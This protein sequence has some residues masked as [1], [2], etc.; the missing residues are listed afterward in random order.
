MTSTN[1]PGT[2]PLGSLFEAVAKKYNAKSANGQLTGS[3]F[4]YDHIQ[5]LAGYKQRTT[6]GL[7]KS[8]VTREL[9][10]Y[11][12]EFAER[13]DKQLGYSQRDITGYLFIQAE[14]GM[15]PWGRIF[16][17]VRACQVQDRDKPISHYFG[18]E[19][20]IQTKGQA[21]KKILIKLV[22][23]VNQEG[24]CFECRKEFPF[25]DITLDHDIPLSAKGPTELTNMQLMCK[26]C[27]NEKGSKY[28]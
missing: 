1:N 2:T 19:A 25:D 5:S 10:R 4:P 8:D 27:N 22:Q 11:L 17:T 28:G 3:K 13:N 12:K 7:S 20:F 23:Y 16:A 9:A 26:P 21:K 15:L 6:P 18:Y 24:Q 14:R